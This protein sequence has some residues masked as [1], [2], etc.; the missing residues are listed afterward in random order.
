MSQSYQDYVNRRN[1]RNAAAA[2]G[3]N[4]PH[5]NT[6]IIPPDNTPITTPMHTPPSIPMFPASFMQQAGAPPA[7]PA[8]PYPPVVTP[9]PGQAPIPVP[10]YAMVANGYPPNNV[11][12][13]PDRFTQIVVC[14]SSVDEFWT[15]SFIE[16]RAAPA[17]CPTP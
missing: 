13:N 4:P 8:P 3:G 12:W 14:T 15:N 17:I 16:R 7:P 2:A 1:A 5:A 6:G 9:M 10:T 11:N